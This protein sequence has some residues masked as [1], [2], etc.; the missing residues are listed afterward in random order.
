[1]F[2]PSSAAAFLAG[3]APFKVL[4]PQV[5]ERLAVICE[6]RSAAAGA[7]VV[8]EGDED[9]SLF[10]LLE[11]RAEV[12]LGPSRT[13]IAALGPGDSFGETA[14]LTGVGRTASVVALSD[15]RFL[16]LDGEA[17]RSVVAESGEAREVLENVVEE[18]ARARLIRETTAFAGLDDDARRA[19]ARSTQRRRMGTGGVLFSQGEPADAAYLI[20]AGNVQLLRDEGGSDRDVARVGPGALLGETAVVTGSARTATAIA[21]TDLELL[22]MPEQVLST[23]LASNIETSRR[24]AELVRLR[25]RPRRVEGIEVHPKEP[26]EDDTV[27]VLEDAHHHRYFRLSEQGLFVWQRLDGEHNVRDLAVEGMERF[28]AFAPDAIAQL[29][30]RLEAAGFVEGAGLASQTEAGGRSLAGRAYRALTWTKEIPALHGLTDAVYRGGGRALFTWPAQVLFAAVALAGPVTLFAS[31]DRAQSAVATVGGVGWALLFGFVLA[32]VIHD[33]GHALATRHYGREVRGGIGFFWLSPIVFIN[34]SDMWLGP[35]RERIVVTL[36]GPY[37]HLIT[38]GVAG[39]LTLV[40]DGL[41]LVIA[42]QFTLFAYAGVLLNLS[43]LLELDGYYLM[44]HVLHRPNLRRRSLAFLVE[45]LPKAFRDPSVLRGHGVEVAY[46]IASLV[47]VLAVT[48]YS[49]VMYRIGIEPWLGRVFS[50]SVTSAIGW[51]LAV[52]L[53]VAVVAGIVGD[54]Q[55]ALAASRAERGKSV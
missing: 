41:A 43:P 6:E 45:D 48:A 7:A 53:M 11:G 33:S 37:A 28:R 15:V 26:P 13:P 16:R 25:Y 47:F 35:K 42:W 14:V 12:Q 44:V 22:E 1:M 55:R 5:L 39:L 36:A 49:I 29:L 52:L 10:V 20:V 34:T 31:A 40:T 27:A 46:G 9:D 8:T 30:A 4:D 24:V 18:L 50:S 3:T 19:L 54:V 23:V 21:A 2:A 38:A 17:V 51:T 32:A